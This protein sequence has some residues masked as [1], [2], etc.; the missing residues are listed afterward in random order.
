MEEIECQRTSEEY[1]KPTIKTST[2]LNSEDSTRESVLNAFKCEKCEKSYKIKYNLKQHV[3]NKH[4]INEALWLMLRNENLRLQIR[5]YCDQIKF[6]KK[7]VLIQDH[8]LRNYGGNNVKTVE[9]NEGTRSISI[10]NLPLHLETH[11][12]TENN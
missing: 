5:I 4:K 6:K 9:R 7:L 2:D 1:L 8:T 11:C 10:S 3:E 12:E